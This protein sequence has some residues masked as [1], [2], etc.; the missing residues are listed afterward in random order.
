MFSAILR[1][2]LASV[3]AIA[4]SAAAVQAQDFRVLTRVYDSRAAKGRTKPV[5]TSTALFHAHKVYD[6]VDS[7]L[8]VTIFEPAH[9][10]FVLVNAER[11]LST[12]IPFR[13]FRRAVE[14]EEFKVAEQAAKL[15]R[16][17]SASELDMANHL[18]FQLHPIFATNYNLDT[19]VLTMD[20]AQ[21]SYK[22]KCEKAAVPETVDVYLDFADWAARLNMLISPTGRLPGARLQVN[23]FLR[24]RK[25]LPIEVTAENHKPDWHLVAE[26]RFEWSLTETDRQRI[27]ECEGLLKEGLK[28]VTFEEYQKARAKERLRAAR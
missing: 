20:G 27:Q 3:V 11:H 23:D 2:T 5:S 26:H 13:V 10:R 24:D 17:G 16:S 1:R 25:L 28:Q 8:E 15:E 12:V 22:L 21:L 7:A 9:D 14:Q 19:S 4:V 6:S 18:K